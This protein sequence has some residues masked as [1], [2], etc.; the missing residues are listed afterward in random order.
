MGNA[1]STRS[2]EIEDIKALGVRINDEKSFSRIR[3]LL[4]VLKVKNFLYSKGFIGADD[5]LTTG[6]NPFNPFARYASRV[7]PNDA[8]QYDISEEFMVCHNLPENDNQWNDPSSTSGAMAGPDANGPGHVFM[9]STNLHWT[10]FNILTIN[11]V[12]FLER[13]KVNAEKYVKGRG[14]ARYGFYFHCFPLNS[15][16]S[17]HLHIVNLDA[18]GPHFDT[19]RTKNLHLDDAITVISN[20]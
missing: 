14:W 5:F 16:Q 7:M 15:V 6:T 1:C 2:I 13:L 10:K 3:D 17:L 8:P 20:N 4:S 19:Q 9:T 18:I 12:S 11:D